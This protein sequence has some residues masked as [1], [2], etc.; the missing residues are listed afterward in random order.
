NMFTF[1]PPA[2]SVWA[3]WYTAASGF[4]GFLRWAYNSWTQSPLTDTRFISW[5]AGDTYQVYPGPLSS[6]RFEK[7]IEGIQDYEKI[8]QLRKLYIANNNASKL[9]E[10]D[11]ALKSFAIE[12]LA[13][14]SAEEMLN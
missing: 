4:D 13:K 1:S 9:H 2:E 10:L 12:N 5:P 8:Q 3:G 7:L 11:E 6:V 14:Q